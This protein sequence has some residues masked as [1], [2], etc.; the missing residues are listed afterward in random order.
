MQICEAGRLVRHRKWYV[1]L[2]C[3]IFVGQQL[4]RW[5]ASSSSCTVA[6][7][8]GDDEG[9][10]RL[11]ARVVGSFLGRAHRCRAV[12]AVSTKT[13]P[14]ELHASI[15][16]SG[17]FTCVKSH[18]CTTTT[19]TTTT[20]TQ[21]QTCLSPFLC[22]VAI[23]F[24]S[25]AGS[26]SLLEPPSVADSGGCACGGDMSSSPSAWRS[27]SPP[28]QLWPVEEEGGGGAKAGKRWST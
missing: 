25:L 9:G 15:G 19:T 24:L 12:G 16:A 18:V 17:F 11:L 14:P 21:V 27:L 28:P 22:K 23:S 1:L 20:T 2:D 10:S 4:E 5:H 7:P 3:V 6:L 26:F 13:W 8:H